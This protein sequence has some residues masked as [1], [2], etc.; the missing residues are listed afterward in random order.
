M[1]YFRLNNLLSD[2]QFGFL[3]GRSANIQ[4]IRVMDDWTKY[5]DLGMS[6]DVVYLDFMKACDKVSH[7]HLI[8][9][10]QHLEVHHNILSW[11]CNFLNDRFQVVAYLSS[12]TLFRH[13]CARH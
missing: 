10:L 12:R 5:L 8:H 1:D 4:M 11:I 2:N 13:T 3:K 7:K 6:V 9:K